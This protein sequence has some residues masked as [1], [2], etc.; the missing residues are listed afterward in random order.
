MSSRF[1]QVTAS[2]SEAP[3]LLRSFVKKILLSEGITGRVAEDLV[4]AVYEAVANV[5][6]H[7]YAGR[8]GEEIR[9]EIS[10]ENKGI[11]VL[12][13]SGGLAFAGKSEPLEIEGL[14]AEKSS[15]GLGL[16]LIR[17]LVDELTHQRH[18]DRNVTRLFIKIS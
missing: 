9:L 16:A 18:N 17:S 13:L 6:E 8:A 4:L 14:I 3:G 11:E 15:G 10:V 7:A 12:I 5:V 2:S 1:S